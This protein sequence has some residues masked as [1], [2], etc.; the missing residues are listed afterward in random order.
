MKR[1]YRE[2]HWELV[3]G[4]GKLLRLTSPRMSWNV[5]SLRTKKKNRM[6]TAKSEEGIAWHKAEGEAGR[7]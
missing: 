4:R 6:G 1:F 2:S 3:G 5:E 7:G